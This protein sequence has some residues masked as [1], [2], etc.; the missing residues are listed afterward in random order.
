MK[1]YDCF[2]FY[3]EFELLELRLKS[4]YDKVDYFVLVEANKT[5]TNK[6]KPYYFHEHMNEFAEFLP[7]I[8]NVTVEVDL[9]YSGTGDWTIE[10]AQRNM[11]SSGIVDAE[12]D[13]LIFIS[14]ADEIY[15]PNIISRIYDNEENATVTYYLYDNEQEKQ[16][17][18][19]IKA[20]NILEECP[21][22]MS[23]QF[24]TYYFDYMSSAPWHG[25]I[26]TK[27]KNITT[28]QQLRSLRNEYP[29]MLNG[30]Y[31]FSYMGGAD[32]IVNKML[33]IVEGNYFAT[34]NN[35]FTDSEY[36]KEKI[37]LGQDIYERTNIPEAQ[38][39]VCDVKKD[40]HL[41]N[42]ES[43]LHKYPYLLREPDKYF[44]F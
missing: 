30:G 41:P 21:I 36:I 24:H 31:H 44:N 12:P 27:Y 29:R 16:Y 1:I 15:D 17:T 32:R 39:L 22:V 10:N 3:N 4:L 38:L 5:Q 25:T 2:P 13:D 37:M 43:F 8:R 7:K 6:S 26:L 11:I 28:P 42:L 9:E 14:D 23:Q 18:T 19:Q 34:F 33:S 35:K 20:K 40:I